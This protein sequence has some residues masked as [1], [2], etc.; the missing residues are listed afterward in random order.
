MQQGR[1]SCHALGSLNIGEGKS[2]VRQE[3]WSLGTLGGVTITL[4]CGSTLSMAVRTLIRDSWD[5]GD[6]LDSLTIV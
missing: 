3:G 4:V 1:V 6:S 2:R 5:S